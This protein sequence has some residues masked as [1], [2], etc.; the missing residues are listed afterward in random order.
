MLSEVCFDDMSKKSHKIAMLLDSQIF[1]ERN[2]I[3]ILFM[4]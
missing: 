2:N 1:G 3:A 4:Q